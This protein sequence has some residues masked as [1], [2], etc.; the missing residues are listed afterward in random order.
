MLVG[1]FPHE[2]ASFDFAI[3]PALFAYPAKSAAPLLFNLRPMRNPVILCVCAPFGRVVYLPEVCSCRE[4]TRVCHPP[5]KSPAAHTT[6]TRTDIVATQ[7]KQLWIGLVEVRPL[8]KRSKILD[9]MKG[10]FVNIVAWAAD[11]GEY[12]R[13]VDLIISRLGGLF[14]SE[15]ANTEPVD[16]RRSRTDG[17]LDEEIED[18]ISRAK[19]NPNAIIYGTFHMFE[20]DD[21]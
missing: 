9:D 3:P 6:S 18:M 11:A 4:R 14:V 8:T 16:A 5:L 13:K 7:Q 12:N 15:I 2:N 10:A 19:T 17:G 21:A 1:P 20:R